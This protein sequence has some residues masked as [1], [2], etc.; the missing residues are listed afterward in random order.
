VSACTSCG[1]R[2]VWGVKE[3]GT[4]IPLDPRAPV[5]RILGTN[6]RGEALV[7]LCP[8]ERNLRDA[9]VS[10]F[11]TCPGA[12]EHSRAGEPDE[13]QL[14]IDGAKVTAEQLEDVRRTLRE[15]A[16]DLERPQGPRS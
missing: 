12:S 14:P 4:R 11:A 9:M 1:R 10:H 15:N 13:R 8:L 16:A 2:I 6:G 3:D 5:Y 7:E